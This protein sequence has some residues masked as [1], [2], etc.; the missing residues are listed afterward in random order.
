MVILLDKLED[1]VVVW[2]VFAA[3]AT[4]LYHLQC[5]KRDLYCLYSFALNG[6]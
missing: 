6:S 4:A 5:V 3:H 1:L 2:G